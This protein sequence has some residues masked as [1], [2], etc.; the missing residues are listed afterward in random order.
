MTK[1]VLQIF[2]NSKQYSSP[3][4]GR[5]DSR[6]PFP[7]NNGV[8]TT[9]HSSNN[10]QTCLLLKV[11][12]SRSTGFD[13]VSVTCDYLR[14]T[15]FAL[16]HHLE[17]EASVFAS[18]LSTPERCI[19]PIFFVAVLHRSH[20]QQIE[21]H[22]NCIDD[23]VQDIERQTGFGNPGRLMGF[24]SKRRA[25]LDEHPVLADARSTIQQL[26]DCQTDLAIIGHVA[27]ACLDCGEGVVCAIDE[28]LA[29]K[30]PRHGEQDPFD[31]FEQF[32][33]DQRSSENLRAIRLM[34]RQDVEYM[35]RRT[36]MLLSQM[37]A[38]RER[39]ESQTSFVSISW[40]RNFC[41]RTM[42]DKLELDAEHHHAK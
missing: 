42:V 17:D 35:R 21:T 10:K 1:K 33:L 19:E 30:P 12:N 32:Q 41:Y 15:T 4:S 39:A 13:C 2:G 11:A 24:G 22:R 8:F 28:S 18:L 37:Q 16:Y 9:F 3:D 38:I 29:D 26:S 14:R 25:S 6:Y 7:S 40:L 36:K 27:R 31:G 34:I 23:A 20:H 5:A